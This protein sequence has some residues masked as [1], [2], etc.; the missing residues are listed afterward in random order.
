MCKWKDLPEPEA[1]F[2]LEGESAREAA[3]RANK[4]RDYSGWRG[5]PC[6]KRTGC[7]WCGGSGWN[8]D[9][10]NLVICARCSGTGVLDPAT[11]RP[12]DTDPWTSDVSLIMKV[13]GFLTEPATDRRYLIVNPNNGR[14]CVTPKTPPGKVSDESIER[15]GYKRV[16]ATFEALDFITAAAER[17]SLNQALLK[18]VEERDVDAK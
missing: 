12:V 13:R 9:R 18:G 8:E 14:L 15:S 11:G 1:G 5:C 10:A 4:D 17:C 16:S 3:I 7:I 2:P 6:N